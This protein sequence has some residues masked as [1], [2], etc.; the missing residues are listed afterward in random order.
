MTPTMT[1]PT[2]TAPTTICRSLRRAAADLP[3][4]AGLAQDAGELLRGIRLLQQFEAVSAALRQHV[5][6]S[7]GQYDRHVELAAADSLGEVEAGHLR[8]HYIRKNDIEAGGVAGQLG[9]CVHRIV[10]QRG[11]VA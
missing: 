6:V 9:Q 3:A 5:A 8:H 2:M 7:A 11:G 10:D 1:A 4:A